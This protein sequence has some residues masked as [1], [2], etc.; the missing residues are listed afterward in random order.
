[1]SDTNG[2]T[3]GTPPPDRAW[4]QVGYRLPRGGTLLTPLAVTE[5]GEIY[6]AARLS[7]KGREF[8]AL[9]LASRIQRHFTRR[10]SKAST[11]NSATVRVN[12][13][14]SKRPVYRSEPFSPG[15]STKLT[16]SPSTRPS[17]ISLLLLACVVLPANSLP[18]PL[19]S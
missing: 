3:N 4:H 18:D 15:F 6:L 12:L 16:R 14:P 9:Y 17:A 13:T 7:E 1:M 8:V 11:A 5:T 19:N 10:A 2:N